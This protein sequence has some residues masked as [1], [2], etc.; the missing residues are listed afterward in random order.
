M[1]HPHVLAYLPPALH[2]AGNVYNL[3]GQQ[4][5]TFIPSY[6]LKLIH[7][8]SPRPGHGSVHFIGTASAVGH[9]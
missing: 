9:H 8:L 5:E 4:N 7:M 1:P 6:I 2:H 3:K